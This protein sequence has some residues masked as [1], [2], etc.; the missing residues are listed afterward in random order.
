MKSGYVKSSARALSVGVLL[1]VL[2]AWGAAV[3]PVWPSADHR[4]AVR[5]E[6]SD[7]GRNCLSY[8]C[9]Q[10]ATD[11]GVQIRDA[12]LLMSIATRTTSAS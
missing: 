4:A 8:P 1:S 6:L 10:T 9:D 11:S 2:S 5:P 3:A 7:G 12:G